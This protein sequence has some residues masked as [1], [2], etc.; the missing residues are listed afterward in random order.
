MPSM[1]ILGDMAEL[2]T[3]SLQEHE[4]L[5][6]WLKTLNFQQI[7]LVGPQFARVCEPT[8]EIFVFRE[9]DSLRS[10]LETH[11]PRGFTILVKGSRVM[12]LERLMP[13]LV[14]KKS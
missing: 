11:P 10:H 9:L 12:E 2:G 4:A 14:G 5:V 1:L 7:L 13:Q 3:A 8:G 6:G